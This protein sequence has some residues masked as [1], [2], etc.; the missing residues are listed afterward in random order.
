MSNP[1]VKKFKAKTHEQWVRS[2][3]NKSNFAKLLQKNSNNE[4]KIETSMEI[5]ENNELI[6]VVKVWK[7][8]K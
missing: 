3:I 4:N 6:N 2:A 7:K 5:N 1:I 8:K